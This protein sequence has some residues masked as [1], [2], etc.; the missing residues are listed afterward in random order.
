M[1]RGWRVRSEILWSHSWRSK[2]MISSPSSVGVPDEV[3]SQVVK[4]FVVSARQVRFIAK[5]YESERRTS[6]SQT[7]RPAFS[8]WRQFGLVPIA[9]ALGYIALGALLALSPAVFAQEGAPWTHPDVLKAASDVRMSQDQRPQ[10]RRAVTAFLE[11]F[12][13]DVKRLLNARSPHDLPRKIASKRRH[14]VKEMDKTMQAF[15]MPGQ[16]PAYEA[17]RDL[18]L[19]KM[20]ERAARIR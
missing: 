17:Y 4:A 10:F 11:G 9:G 12:N 15:L 8:E 14:R 5:R 2:H 3:R 18:L 7:H 6:V 13:S 1:E 16:I 19:Q 20:D